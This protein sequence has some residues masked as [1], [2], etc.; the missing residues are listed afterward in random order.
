[1]TAMTNPALLLD[2]DGVLVV[3]WKPVPGAVEAMRAIRAAGLPGEL[4]QNTTSRA[5]G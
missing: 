5:M 1:M 4:F 2:I 3:S